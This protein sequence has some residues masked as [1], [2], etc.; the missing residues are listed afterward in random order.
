M[1]ILLVLFLPIAAAC[2]VLFFP[3]VITR[4]HNYILHLL[5]RTNDPEISDSPSCR[6]SAPQQETTDTAQYE[7]DLSVFN[8]EVQQ[9]IQQEG[10]SVID[11]FS[12]V[13][14]GSIHAPSDKHSAVVRITI[15]DVTDGSTSARPVQARAKQWQAADSSVF[16]YNTDLGRLPNSVTVLSDWTSVAKL[17]LDW[18]VFARKGRRS[19]LFN[20]SILSAQDGCELACA[21]CS[22]FYDNPSFG[23]LDVQDN[24]KRT[25]TLAVALAFAVSA[26]DKK[27]YECEIELI[28]RWAK[29]N[30][31][32]DEYLKPDARMDE[33]LTSEERK[34]DKALNEVVTFF[35]EGNEFDEYEIC[36]EIVEIAAIDQRL[37][38]L[39][40]CLQVAKA[41]GVVVG[42]ELEILRK[43]ASW[44]EIDNEKFRAMMEKIIPIEMLE[45]KDAESILGVTSDM[46]EE[47]ARAH[48]NKEYV[49]WNA[50]VT[51]TNPEIQSQADQMLKFIAEA[52]TQYVQSNQH[53]QD[54]SEILVKQGKTRKKT[55]K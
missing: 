15:Q 51:N 46:D 30:I 35:K 24:L 40:L 36:S 27:I 33:K 10:E 44:F 29:D 6:E 43:I 54:Q 23:Y 26:V 19:L 34:L 5:Y 9:T 41:N 48:L 45:D 1:G 8:C 28:K 13:I 11:I 18:L 3:N 50:R 55:P 38:I 47:K 22:C 2:V 42:C 17:R 14:C 20:V 16:C 52:R 53:E 12:V 25:K 37:D 4:L 32:G 7:P 39:E 31:L 21:R 49:K